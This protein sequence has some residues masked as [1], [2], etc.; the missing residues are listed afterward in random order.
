M[1]F[2]EDMAAWAKKTGNKMDG[3]IKS[4]CLEM[5]RLVMQRTPV[6]DPTYWQSPA[7]PGYVGGR[8]RN[9][10]MPEINKID[11]STTTVP[12]KNANFQ[13]AVPF[14]ANAP[15]NIFYLTNSLPYIQR[16]EY[17]Y[18]KQAPGGIVR[19]SVQEFHLVIKKAIK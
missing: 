14:V 7:P 2:A 11:T 13:R 12:D 6:G 16:L 10:W 3:T 18:S 19:L 8:A 5:T 4:T 9:N 15:G 17:G 1:G